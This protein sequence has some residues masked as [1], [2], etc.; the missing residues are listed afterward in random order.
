MG[1]IMIEGELY[2]ALPPNDY[3]I[4]KCIKYCGGGCY[5]LKVIMSKHSRLIGYET[6]L[7][8]AL[9]KFQKLYE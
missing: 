3:E 1:K 5:K 9:D 6:E 2:I 8:I 4:V 7:K